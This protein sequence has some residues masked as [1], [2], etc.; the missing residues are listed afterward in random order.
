VYHAVLVINAAI[1]AL[2]M[3]LAYVMGRRLGLIRPAAYAVAAVTALLPAGLFY[4]EYAM[5]DAIY[6][7][8]VLAWLLTVHTWLTVHISGRSARGQYAAAVGS[9]LLGGYAYAVHSRGTP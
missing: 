7:V 9:A 6:P 5:A 1:S 4:S 8:L 2:L 3:P